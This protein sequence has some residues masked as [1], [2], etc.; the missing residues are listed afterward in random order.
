MDSG[1]LGLGFSRPAVVWDFGRRAV[2]ATQPRKKFHQLRKPIFQVSNQDFDVIRHFGTILATSDAARIRVAS[3]ARQRQ[4]T[5]DAAN[6]T[7]PLCVVVSRFEEGYNR[8]HI[9]RFADG[10][11]YV[12]R[13]PCWGQGGQWKRDDA[14]SLRSQALMMR[15]I[16]RKTG[17]RL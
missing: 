15:F 5:T 1:L 8:I 16:K 13:I 12:V 11:K 7:V 6:Q 3:R 9:L 14:I 17:V 2:R 4:V 10:V